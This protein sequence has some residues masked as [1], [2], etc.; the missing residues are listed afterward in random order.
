LSGSA[1]DWATTEND[2]ADLALLVDTGLPILPI[3]SILLNSVADLI[4]DDV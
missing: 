1:D 2:L 3:L 4:P